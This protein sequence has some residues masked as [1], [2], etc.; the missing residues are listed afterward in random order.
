MSTSDAEIQYRVMRLIEANPGKSQRELAREL[1][2]SLGKLNNCVQALVRQGW[3]KATQFKNS[4]NKAAHMYLLTRL[5][6]REKSR[7]AAQ[8]LTLK[9]IQYEKLGIEI[10]QMRRE[11]QGR[12]S[13]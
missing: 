10:E 2:V 4:Q 9:M 3:L 8:F 13:R 5:G 11:T 1:N 6:N 12:M 7:L